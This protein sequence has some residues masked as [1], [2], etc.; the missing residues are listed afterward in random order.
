MALWA[1]LPI[2]R[3]TVHKLRNLVAHAPKK[4]ADETH[5]TL[6]Q[7]G[8]EYRNAWFVVLGGVAGALA[9]GHFDAPITALFAEKDQKLTFAEMI[10]L[11]F[12]T[13]ALA[14]ALPLLGVL[15]GLEKWRPW[16]HVVG[17]DHDRLLPS[18]YRPKSLTSDH[19]KTDVFPTRPGLMGIGMPKQRNEAVRQSKTQPI[20]ASGSCR[21]FRQQWR[22]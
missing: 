2:Q 20:G 8:A 22:Q 1:D 7:L 3:C 18:E 4:L 15:V 13:L 17:Q 11:P 16:R 12:W 9:Y 10:M 5:T 14:F 21:G 19:T 6:A